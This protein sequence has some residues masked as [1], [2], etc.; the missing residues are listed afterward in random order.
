MKSKEKTNV[1]LLIK[2]IDLVFIVT[3][4]FIVAF[5]ASLMIRKIMSSI[6]PE[7]ETNKF[8]LALEIVLSIVL[9]VVVSYFLRNMIQIIPFP[10]DG[11]YGFDHHRVKEL[12]GGMLTTLLF[13]FNGKMFIDAKRLFDEVTI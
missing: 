7:N 6:F 5:L 3:I 4:Y 12:Q 10:L 8:L 11:I 13:L 2:I 9:I 1:F